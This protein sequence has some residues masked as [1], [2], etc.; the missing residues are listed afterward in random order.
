M[1]SENDG[2][3]KIQRLNEQ[4]TMPI[5]LIGGRT[6]VLITVCHVSKPNCASNSFRES[7]IVIF[8]IDTKLKLELKLDIL[9]VDFLIFILNFLF[10]I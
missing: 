4:N 3:K 6:N 1:G 7:S 2:R 5:R 8:E 9:R 10:F